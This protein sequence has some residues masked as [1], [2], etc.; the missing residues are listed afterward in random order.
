VL[1]TG[2]IERPLVFGGNDRPGVMLASAARSYVNRYAVRPGDHVFVVTN[3]DSAYAAALDLKRAGAAVTA[4]VDLRPDPAGALPKAARAAG[5]RIM[6][7]TAVVATEGRLRIT[8]VHTAPITPDGG[9]GLGVPVPY[10]CDLLLMSGGWNPTVSLFSQS[11]G[12][13]RFDEAIAAFVPGEGTQPQRSAGAC[14]GATTLR[15]ALEQGAEAGTAAARDAGFAAERPAIPAVEEPAQDPLLPV[16]LVPGRKRAWVDFQNDVTAKDLGIAVREGFTSIEH[17]KRYTTTGMGTDQGKTSNVNALAIV[18]L[19]RGAGIE[20]VGTT[21][22]RP[23]YTP[24]TFGAIA[25]LNREEL[26][27][28]VRT[29]SIHSWHAEHGAVFE[30]V[31]SW[32]RPRYY[33]RAGEDM[34]AATARECR[35]VRESVGIFDATTLG[36]IDLQGADAGT[37]LDRVYTNLFSTLEPGRCRYG[38]MCRDDGY[39]FDDGVTSRLAPDRFHMTTTTGGAARVL[40]WLEEWLQTEWP[41]LKVYCTSVTEEWAVIA[42]AGPR[43]RDVLRAIGT[44]IDLSPEAFPHLS[45]RAGQV[46]GVPARVFRVSFSGE[47]AYEINVP[48][49]YGRPVW[50]ALV[51]AGQPF[52]ITPYG[53][54]A[55]HVLR[56]EKGYIIVGQDTDGTVTP[57]DLG[58]GWIVSKKK[59]DFIGKRG[60]ARSD[61][62]RP[63]RKQLVGL[64]TDDPTEVLE[65]GAQL[66]AGADPSVSLGHVTSSYMSPSLGRPIALALVRAGRERLGQTL[67]VPMPGRSIPVRVVE[68]VFVDPKGERLHA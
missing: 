58:M 57:L 16:W 30:D 66:T 18:A 2:A 23:P 34:H 53:T 47:L 8:Q 13:L 9:V 42:L 38:L 10:R 28:P 36:K 7:G 52:G 27:D 45:W 6:P 19:K 20:D 37:F 21:T 35:A 46:A 39:V 25:G 43:S 65:E 62:Q 31:G 4:V 48:A 5:I 64:M 11:R 55:M 14:K 68:P 29:T 3:N 22:F 17:V 26:F 41:E 44:D 15:A 59:P 60:M 12:R 56:A 40:S 33:P 63:D 61:L 24:V 50:E 54:E 49:G 1:A 32:K 67:H 51:R